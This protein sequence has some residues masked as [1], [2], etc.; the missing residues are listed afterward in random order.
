MTKERNVRK[1]QIVMG[2]NQRFTELIP[3]NELLDQ[4][5]DLTLLESELGKYSAALGYDRIIF[6]LFSVYRQN[7]ISEKFMR[8][9]LA[10]YYGDKTYEDTNENLLSTL[11]RQ[12]YQTMMTLMKS[13]SNTRNIYF[14]EDHKIILQ[15]LKEDERFPVIDLV[16]EKIRSETEDVQLLVAQVDHLKKLRKQEK[17]RKKRTTQTQAATATPQIIP[18]ETAPIVIPPEAGPLQAEIPEHLQN[19][20]DAIFLLSNW[21][22]YWTSNYFSTQPHH[23]TQIP[24]HERQATIAAIKAVGQK[25]ISISIASLVRAL[26]FYVQKDTI[27]RALSARN[28]YA[29]KEIRDWV[30]IKRGKDRI[31]LYIPPESPDNLI[32]FADGRDVIYK[33][34]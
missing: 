33:G 13:I 25:Q 28:K 4:E 27:Q 21:Q 34:L 17:Q 30:K 23:L 2:G 1:G 20:P 9:S 24:T 19:V 18:P 14:D 8:T 26:E 29:P 15:L 3:M 11:P 32:F 6:N 5:N 31:M 7:N 22:L 10:V 12:A 16:A